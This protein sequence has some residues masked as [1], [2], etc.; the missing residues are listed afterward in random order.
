M[1]RHATQK[2]LQ[3]ALFLCVGPVFAQDREEVAVSQTSLDGRWTVKAVRW[4]G[5]NLE[6]FAKEFV[7]HGGTLSVESDGRVAE[8]G[9]I[10][11]RRKSQNQI[12]VI[13]EG[14]EYVRLGIY[15][16][17]GNKLRLAFSAI[18]PDTPGQDSK[19]YDRASRLLRPTEF[20][21][22]VGYIV[23]EL[24]RQSNR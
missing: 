16:L 2:L 1:D 17:E 10:V 24:V 8:R 22:T 9:K 3:I 18:V 5:L 23:F 13:H 12:D 6:T 21:D 7:I 15:S 19:W 11:L 4:Q 20:N 14:S